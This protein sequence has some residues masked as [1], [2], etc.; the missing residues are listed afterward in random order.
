MKKI[1]SFFIF[2]LLYIN[3]FSQQMGEAVYSIKLAED[4]F[5]FDAT[6]LFESSKS[7][8]SYKIFNKNPWQFNSDELTQTVYSDSIGYI[9]FKNKEKFFVRQYCSENEVFIYEDFIQLNWNI[10]EKERIIEGL[11]CKNATTTFRGRSYNVWFSPAIP[12]TCGPW[13]FQGLPGLIVS[14]TD[15]NLD[16]IIKLKS[17]EILKSSTKKIEFPFNASVIDRNEFEKCLQKSWNNDLK[18]II[19]KFEGIK[20]KYPNLEIDIDIPDE[21]PKTELDVE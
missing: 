21:R 6:L 10:T 11:L 9:Y 19:A 17:L 18:R 1:L 3:S 7:I 4:Y 8:F 16:V 20:A 5:E 13:K 15:S 12:T 14:V 2:L